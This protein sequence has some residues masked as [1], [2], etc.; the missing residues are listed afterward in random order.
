M[1]AEEVEQMDQGLSREG[2]AALAYAGAGYPVFPVNPKTKAPLTPNGFK[3]A[4]TD[5][6]RVRQLWHEDPNAAIGYAIPLGRFVLDIDPRNGGDATLGEIEHRRGRLPYTLEVVTPGGGWHLH[7]MLPEDTPAIRVG[8]DGLGPGLDVK[9]GGSSYVILPPSRHPNGGRYS[10]QNTGVTEPEMAPDWLVEL[11]V[12]RTSSVAAPIPERIKA[13]RNSTLASLAGSMRRR[14][15]SGPAILAALSEENRT[16]CDPPLPEKEVE[17]IARSISRYKPQAVSPVPESPVPEAGESPWDRA[18]PIGSFLE[19]PE[20]EVDF[21]GPHGLLARGCITEIFS[22]RGI[23]KTHVAHWLAKSLSRAELRGLILD[24]DNPKSRVKSGL[25]QWGATDGNLHILTRD[26]APRLTDPAAWQK[27]PVEKYDF[28]ILDSLDAASEGVG[29]QDS[30]KPSKALAPL[31]DVARRGPAVFVLGN[32]VKSAAHSRGSGVVEDRADIVFEIRD[33]TGLEPSG[34][35]PWWE[36]LAAQ[37]ANHWVSRATRR[38][39]RATFRLAFVPTKYRMGEEPDPFCL[40]LR[41][42]DDSPW[43]IVDVTE[44]LVSAGEEAVA[45]EYRERS[46]RRDQAL[47]ALEA[48]LRRSPINLTEAVRF[49]RDRGLSR[50]DA[51]AA[52]DGG[53]GKRWLRRRAAGKQGR[54]EFLA[55]IPEQAP[56]KLASPEEAPPTGILE[57]SVSPGPKGR[58]PEKS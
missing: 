42:G 35:K 19:G 12:S 46:G 45:R 44:V 5:L 25:R 26:E 20:E 2:R 13:G 55:A 9:M 56:E 11:L 58:G 54:P 4:T 14:G 17:R 10:W 51:R 33:A 1:P 23:G 50:D 28:V 48:E 43:E 30:A 8:N 22:P 21:L 7:L 6:G 32:T 41:L 38:R 18:I 29:E 31:L 40:E 53:T 39:R 49:L 52:I 27:F 16:R 24:R 15:A 57:G 34:E 47:A 36:E 3:D 37:G